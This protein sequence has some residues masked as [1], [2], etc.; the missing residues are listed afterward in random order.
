MSNDEQAIIMAWQRGDEQAVRTLFERYYPRAV[1]IAVLSG[2]SREEALDCAQDVF[3]RAFERRMQLRDPATFPLW[4]QRITTR[5][6]LTLLK[7][8]RRSTLVPLEQSGELEEDWG[9]I[10]VPLPEDLA[11]S[12][13]NRLRL[14]QQ[15]QKLL[16]KYRVPLVLRYY[17]DFSF[18]EIADIL[19]QREGTVRVLVHRALQELRQHAQ[20]ALFTAP[21]LALVTEST[22]AK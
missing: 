20:E 11:I 6:I 22:C 19:G 21:S 7:G 10:Q 18:R 5:Q 13:E 17:G 14:W 9:R 3:V 12:A 1:R 8:R 4:F 2:L 15:V 16:P